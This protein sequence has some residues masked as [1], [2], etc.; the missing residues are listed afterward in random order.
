MWETK[1]F[2]QLS[3]KPYEDV[4]VEDHIFELEFLLMLVLVDEGSLKLSLLSHI[5]FLHLDLL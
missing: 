2:Y 1:M 4:A 3:Y 5:E